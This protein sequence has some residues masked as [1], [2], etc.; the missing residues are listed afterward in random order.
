MALR[1]TWQSKLPPNYTVYIEATAKAH[2]LATH[3]SFLYAAKPCSLAATKLQC[4]YITTYSD[5]AL[6]LELNL[7]AVLAIV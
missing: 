2:R 3:N 1:L 5:L 6:Y 4:L 7:L